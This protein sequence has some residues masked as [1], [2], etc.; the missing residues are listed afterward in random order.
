MRRGGAPRRTKPITPLLTCNGDGKGD[1]RFYFGGLRGMGGDGEGGVEGKENFGEEEGE[2]MGQ[3]EDGGGEEEEGDGRRRLSYLEQWMKVVETVFDGEDHLFDDDERGCLS[4]FLTLSADAKELFIKLML[5]KHKIERL[6]KLQFPWVENI[7]EAADDLVGVGFADSGVVGEDEEE[8]LG[9]LLGLLGREELVVIAKGWRV[10]VG[11]LTV[12]QIRQALLRASENQTTLFG[13]GRKRDAR[14]VLLK[15]VRGV[16]GKT[17]RLSEVTIAVFQRTNLKK[18]PSRYVSYRIDRVTITWPTR[19]SL[20][21]YIEALT[22]EH[23]I[24]LL[25]EGMPRITPAQVPRRKKRSLEGREK[26]VGGMEREE[27]QEEWDVP[28]EL[29]RWGEGVLEVL[30][31]NGRVWDESVGE[32]GHVSGGLDGF[33]LGSWR[34]ILLFAG[35]FEGHRGLWYDEL[36]LTLHT[37]DKASEALEVCKEGLE[38]PMV[39]GG[40][41]RSIEHRIQRLHKQLQTQEKLHFHLINS[42]DNVPTRTVTASKLPSTTTAKAIY[43]DPEGTERTVEDLALQ[44]WIG[45]GWKGYHSENSIITTLF[46]LLFW[47]VIFD[48]SVVGVFV[49]PFQDA[50]LDLLTEFFWEARREKIEKRL[51]VIRGGGFR[52]VL[53]EVEGR[54]RVGRTRCRGVNWKM[55]TKEE[56][57]EIAE[58]FGGHALARI[59]EG[60]CKSYW[61]HSGGVPDLCVWHYERKC[62]KLIEVKGEGDRLSSSQKVWLEFLLAADVDVEVFHVALPRE[63][64]G[65]RPRKRRT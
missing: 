50:P 13:S 65:K 21:L 23:H 38:D 31:G 48:D 60:F 57:L 46:G 54:E 44:H 49:S 19:H 32:G 43:I 24:S 26:E 64:G 9:W 17:I 62:V 3:G 10:G 51:E 37:N 7:L 58:C 34:L 30:E 11:G 16:V 12:D 39:Q 27:E 28:E 14:D 42:L 61:A 2:G 20:N 25:V 8:E 35:D 47:D 53:E 5:R 15:T 4:V 22:L 59:C 52:E 56:V 29:R 6:Y 33:G 18:D 1:I 41:R 45:E 55:F 40:C 36:A 63:D